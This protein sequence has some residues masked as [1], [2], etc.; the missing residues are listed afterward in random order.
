MS[1]ET[2][3]KT[4]VIQEI[5]YKDVLFCV[6]DGWKL[7]VVVPVGANAEELEERICTEKVCI[8]PKP[9]GRKKRKHIISS[10]K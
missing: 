6:D 10:K 1:E 7:K 8:K 4:E 2:E 3:T 5:T 9:K